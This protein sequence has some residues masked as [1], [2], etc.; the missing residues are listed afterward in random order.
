MKPEEK[1]MSGKR[2][3]FVLLV[4]MTLVATVLGGCG[5]TPAPIVPTAVPPTAKPTEIPFEPMTYAAPNC[6]YGGEFLS[7]EA[8]DKLTVKFT[9]CFADPA[10]P[11]KAAFSAF[12]INDTA[13]LESTGGGG[14]L[15]ALPNGTGPFK[16][17]RWTRGSELV[18]TRNDDYWGE[19]PAFK[20]LIFRWNAEAAA[21]LVELQAGTVDG[22]DNIAPAADRAPGH[23]HLLPGHEQHLPAL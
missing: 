17:E 19:K 5:P 21:R 11:S 14:D 16:L 1:K 8:V 2:V 22:I 7:I 23:Q 13:Y 20:T 18:L 9:L 6:D 12:P 15:V 4:A 10:F 3:L